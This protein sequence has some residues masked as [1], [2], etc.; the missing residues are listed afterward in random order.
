MIASN[1]I[2]VVHSDAF[3]KATAA[4]QHTNVKIPVQKKKTTTIEQ[5]IKLEEAISQLQ[6]NCKNAKKN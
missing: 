5:I 3:L 2:T 4:E 1:T 6:K